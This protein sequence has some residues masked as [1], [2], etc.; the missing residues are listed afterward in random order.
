MRGMENLPKVTKVK[1]VVKDKFGRH[2]SKPGDWGK[3]VHGL[4]CGIFPF[5]CFDTV[6]WATGRAS[7]L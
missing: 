2:P 4:G 1:L 3:Q 5:Q 6:G 7:S